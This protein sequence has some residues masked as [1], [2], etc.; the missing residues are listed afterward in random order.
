M[1]IKLRGRVANKGKAQGEA[2]TSYNPFS[3]L[4]AE[5]ST[6]IVYQPGHE[7]HGQTIKDKILI[8]PTGC[9]PAGYHLF[10]MKN[11]FAAPKAIVNMELFYQQVGDALSAEIPMMYG[12]NLNLFDIIQTGDWVIVNADEGIIT[13]QKR[14]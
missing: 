7:F 11:S 6:G 9:G 5:T 2:L 3:F 13:V 4:Q 12:F 14:S 10:L 8:Y 1:E